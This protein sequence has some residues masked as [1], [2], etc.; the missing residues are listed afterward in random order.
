MAHS[1]F[2][3]YEHCLI[4]AFLPYGHYY[5]HCDHQVLDDLQAS[6]KSETIGSST[7]DSSSDSSG[8]GVM[9][10]QSFGDYDL[11]DMTTATANTNF[12]PYNYL[13]PDSSAD[14]DSTRDND[15]NL[16]LDNSSNGSSS[17]SGLKASDFVFPSD[18]A[19]NSITGPLA[20]TSTTTSDISSDSS[21][22]TSVSSSGSSGV[23]SPQN[24]AGMTKFQLQMSGQW[25]QQ[26]RRG[27]L[28]IRLT[29]RF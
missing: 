24:T 14:G 9:G 26:V 20:S 4:I 22:S 18:L 29:N 5:I 7:A 23:S 3:P 27:D 16:D 10:G 13:D 19:N 17:G 2:T 12:P 11:A 15:R 28:F 21:G 1:L 8:V 6:S 25:N